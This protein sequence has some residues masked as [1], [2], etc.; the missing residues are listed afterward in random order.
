VPRTALAVAYVELGQ[1]DAAR[2]VFSCRQQNDDGNSETRNRSERTGSLAEIEKP[3]ALSDFAAELWWILLLISHQPRAP[4]PAATSTSRSIT[5][6][7][8]R[9]ILQKYGLETAVRGVETIDRIPV[10]GL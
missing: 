5:T 3:L 1:E 10:P 6:Q 9:Y 8:R 4:T 2:K 7:S